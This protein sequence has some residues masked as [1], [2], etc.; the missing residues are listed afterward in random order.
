MCA[1]HGFML[2]LSCT[3]HT[4]PGSTSLPPS[5]NWAPPPPVPTPAPSPPPLLLLRSDPEKLACCE[6]C[7]RLSASQLWA[8]GPAGREA[9]YAAEGQAGL[10]VLLR[11]VLTATELVAASAADDSWQ[12]GRAAS[13]VCQGVGGIVCC[14]HSQSLAQ[15]LPLQPQAAGMT[16]G[17]LPTAAGCSCSSG[18]GCTQG[19]GR[20]HSSTMLAGA[21]ALTMQALAGYSIDVGEAA[22]CRRR[23]L[24][25]MEAAAAA[26]SCMMQH[27][28]G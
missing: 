21:S 27:L 14:L 20:Q 10:G 25:F 28:R 16:G 3:A 4:T 19:P 13:H 15:I 5:A 22:A 9:A 23:V 11:A 8:A 6:Q 26:M 7:L 2:L 18:T 24:S 12:V 1:H 17:S